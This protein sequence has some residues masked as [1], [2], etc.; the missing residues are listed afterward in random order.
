MFCK[1]CGARIDDGSAFCSVCGAKISGKHENTLSQTR[2]VKPAAGKNIN[3]PQLIKYLEMGVELEK[4]KYVQERALKILDDL[5]HRLGVKKSFNKPVKQKSGFHFDGA[6]LGGG[7]GIGVTL[8]VIVFCVSCSS[9][10]SSWSVDGAFG[11]LVGMPLIGGIIGLF[12]SVIYAIVASASAES[13]AEH[14]YQDALNTYNS[15]LVNDSRRVENEL[16]QKEIVST[17][18]D[19]L[20]RQYLQTKKT[21]GAFYAK[22][23]LYGKYHNDFAA[24]ASF[25]DYFKSGRCSTLGENRGG[26][27]AY[28]TYEAELLQHR[29]INKLDM[30]IESLEQVKENQWTI[31]SAIQAGNTISNRLVEETYRLATASED[32]AR[33]SAIAAY[34]SQE[35]A[36]ELNQIKWLE[37]FKTF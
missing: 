2:A 1:K 21:L 22:G 20:Y 9:G 3:V 7:F 15:N 32:N 17:E 18:R 27:G 23:V 35:A 13:K 29:I 31:Y 37:V 25:L 34:N 16:K 36:N 14:D 10:C 11:R 26:D 12:G 8:G 19:K 28:N 30:I 24:I 6:I 33:N 4:Q 5:I